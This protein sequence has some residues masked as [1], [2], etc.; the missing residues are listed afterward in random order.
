MRKDY[1]LKNLNKLN[2]LRDTSQHV[3]DMFGSIGNDKY[4]V[5]HFPFLSTSPW[6]LKCIASVGL[7]WEHVSSSLP[8]R[9]PTW[10]EM[11]AVKDLFWTPEDC[12]M[13]LHVPVVDYVNCHPFTLH[14]WKPI[15]VEIPRPPYEL[16][17][18]GKPN[19]VG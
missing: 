11:C 12:V 16:V 9:C 19:K 7:G 18:G 17:G 3:L 14:L 5:F 8:D 15:D 13:Q 1:H 4:G 10:E 2:H 6:K